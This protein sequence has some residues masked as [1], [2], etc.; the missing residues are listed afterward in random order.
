MILKVCGQGSAQGAVERCGDGVSPRSERS[1][2]GGDR[3][4]GVACGPGIELKK[5]RLSAKTD[6]RWEAT[7]RNRS[8][9]NW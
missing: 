1:T 8:M 7:H 2:T 9:D 6:D 5:M 3:E 4:C